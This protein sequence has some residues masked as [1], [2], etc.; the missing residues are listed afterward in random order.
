MQVVIQESTRCELH[1]LSANVMPARRR[2]WKTSRF[3][4]SPRNGSYTF[5]KVALAPDSRSVAAQYLRG[6][7]RVAALNEWMCTAIAP[8]W[9]RNRGL[10]I[11][12][13]TFS[14]Y[15]PK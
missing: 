12:P 10:A 11:G 9:N 2:S 4:V 3:G 14:A 8:G 6:S 15:Q 7:R 5:P 1:A 13:A